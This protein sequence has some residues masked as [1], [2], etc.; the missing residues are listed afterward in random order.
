MRNPLSKANALALL[1]ALLALSAACSV[2]T[3]VVRTVDSRPGVTFTGGPPNASLTIDGK[4]AGF[5]GAYR[6][7]AP[8]GPVVL[9]LEPGTH[10]VEVQDSAGQVIFKQ[11]FFVESEVKTIV[12]H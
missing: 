12:V 5:L 7:D 6:A 8:D 3:T 1:L 9:R 2:P 11:R 10:E 4:R